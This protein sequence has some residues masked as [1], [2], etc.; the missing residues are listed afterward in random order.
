MVLAATDPVALDSV[1]VAILRLF[2]AT[3]GV[4]RGAIFEQ[5]HIARAVELDLRIKNP[6]QIEIIAGDADS[7]SYASRILEQLRI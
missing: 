5:E 2:G 3:A 6:D 4:K 1:G 7:E